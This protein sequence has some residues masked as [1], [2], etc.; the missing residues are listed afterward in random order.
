MSNTRIRAG[1]KVGIGM[2]IFFIIQ[3]LLINEQQTTYHI[4]RAIITGLV[5]GAVAGLLYALVT[6][7]FAKSG[8]VAKSTKIVTGPGESIVFESPANYFKGKKGV[9]GKLYL[10][11]KRLIFKSHK[12]NIQNHQVVIDLTDI[13]EVG[14]YKTSGMVNNGLIVST[15]HNT[16]ERFVVDEADAWEKHLIGDGRLVI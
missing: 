14:R 13:K 8:F 10:T 5:T 11:N 15:I 3:H 4:I 6:G 16:D 2:A 9:D 12:V 7:W 1:L